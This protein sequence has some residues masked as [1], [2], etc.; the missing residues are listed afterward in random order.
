MKVINFVKDFFQNIDKRR[1]VFSSIFSFLL[2]IFLVIGRQMDETR[3]INWHS[4]T[5]FN[6]FIVFI[7][8]ELITYNFIEKIKLK[9]DKKYEIKFWQIF[10]PLFLMSFVILFATY[11]G[12][13]NV[14]I[15]YEYHLYKTGALGTHYPIFY[16]FVF[17]S[18][19]EF[20]H[21]IFGNWE[22][23]VF[24][25]NLIQIIL[26]DLVVAEVIYF[27]SKRLKNKNFT[28][29]MTIFYITNPL[30]MMMIM[31]T[32]HDVGFAAFF[33]L[34]VLETIKMIEEKDYFSKK[35][36]WAK[37]IFYVFMLCI[38]RNN[39]LFAIVPA[40]ILGLIFIKGSRIK[41][42]AIVTIPLILFFGYNQLIVNNVVEKKE[43]IFRESLNIPI[44]QIAR[45]LYYNHQTIW[46]EELNTYFNVECNWAYYGKYPMITDFQK[47]CTKTDYIET[48]FFDFVNY[49]IKIGKK[50]PHRYVEAPFL[51]DLG[52]YY[53]FITYEED[54]EK[55]PTFQGF[56]S[57]NIQEKTDGK[58]SIDIHRYPQIKLV[59]KAMDELI[60]KQKW[61]KIYFFRA[62]WGG[63]FSTILLIFT[64]C[65][66]AIKKQTKYLVPLC[67][68]FGMLLTV[69]L[70]PVVLYRYLFPIVLTIPAMLYVIFKVSKNE[71]K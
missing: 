9:T 11:P 27:L 24:L 53:P 36:N 3:V 1:L 52:A 55:D 34:V 43:S 71:S 23:P 30:Y 46:S 49:W 47:T 60:S 25:L 17:C 57:Y 35:S 33:A 58:E 21:G 48:H 42:G 29:I 32:S 19:M 6:I 66:V 26:V 4:I 41:F 31:S 38:F 68:I 5:L 44:N 8:I 16:N 51:F 59:D 14:D 64:A 62:I 28:T 50:A 63:A 2:S 61:N 13:Y 22:F 20:L 40:L 10:V 69:L 39:G 70:S 67:F 65:Y 45:A 7:I 18:V 15:T 56:V 54:V 12:N 37:Y